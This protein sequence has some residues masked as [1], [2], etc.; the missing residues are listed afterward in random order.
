MVKRKTT[1][2][3]E[4]HSK[5]CM[6]SQHADARML[7]ERRCWGLIPLNDSVALQRCWLTNI[8]ESCLSH[9]MTPVELEE[10]RQARELNN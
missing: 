2:I 6:T 5:T 10:G 1:H 3:H 4:D 7:I 9:C 8:V